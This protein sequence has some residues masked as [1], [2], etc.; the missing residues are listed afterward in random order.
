V[1]GFH[2]ESYGENLNTEIVG[3]MTVTI[4]NLVNS[5]GGVWQL[6]TATAFISVML[7]LLIFFSLQRYFVSGILAGSVKG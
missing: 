3:P 1:S 6:L 5:L 2:M 4:S 7:L